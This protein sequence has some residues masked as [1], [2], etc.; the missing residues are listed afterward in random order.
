MFTCPLPSVFD[1]ACACLK[2]ERLPRLANKLPSHHAISSD[3][4]ITHLSAAAIA[5][6]WA[7]ERAFPTVRSGKDTSGKARR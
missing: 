7:F 3:V 1:S 5:I 2:T 6:N 4:P